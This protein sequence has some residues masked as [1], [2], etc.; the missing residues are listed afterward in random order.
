MDKYQAICE[1]ERGLK[2]KKQIAEA[3]GVPQNTLS[4]WLKNKEAIKAKFLSGELEPERKN[5]RT[6]NFPEVET[7]LL[8]WFN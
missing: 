7:A 3:F 5:A 4:T 8:R 1:V 6:S 2:S